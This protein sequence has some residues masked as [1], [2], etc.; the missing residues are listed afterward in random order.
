MK[1]KLQGPVFVADCTFAEKDT[2]KA[3]GFRWHG[4]GCRLPCVAC[5]AQVPLKVW[6]TDAAA[7]AARLIE[8]ADDVAKAALAPHLEQVSASKAVDADIDIPAPDGL[9]YLGY[10]RAGIAYAKG[11]DRTLI[12]DEMGLGKT[13]Q[14]LGYI[15]ASPE[16]K[17]VLIVC[18]ASLR[19][20]WEREAKKWL[21]RAD[22]FK[23]HIV[24]TADPPPADATFIIV[25]YNRLS[26][27]A[28][29]KVFAALM[30]RQWD[31]LVADEA[32]YC[33]NPKAKRTQA[34]LGVPEK[35]KK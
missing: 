6:W 26:G 27:K 29:E 3:A 17:T 20:N 15:N 30:A 24:E 23:F 34:L 31:L 13:I 10:Q 2:V 21:V 33:K 22:S 1:I 7:K 4:G 5:Q 16:V 19:L 14:A 11:R 35:N 12:G 32:H 8:Y 25:N 9:A 18:P 28:G